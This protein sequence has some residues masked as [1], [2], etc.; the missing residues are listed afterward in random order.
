MGVV[1]Q[2]LRVFSFLWG[3]FVGWWVV[4]WAVLLVA[5]EIGGC[6]GVPVVWRTFNVL[7]IRVVALGV[8]T[9]SVE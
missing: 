9:Q 2:R 7:R 8:F 6:R 5:D 4:H 1:Y 3:E